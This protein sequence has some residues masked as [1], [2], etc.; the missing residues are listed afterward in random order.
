[1]YNRFQFWF[2][3]IILHWSLAM[4]LNPTFK[5]GYNEI[6]AWLEMLNQIT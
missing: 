2:H 6:F 3:L 4:T 1:M 5:L